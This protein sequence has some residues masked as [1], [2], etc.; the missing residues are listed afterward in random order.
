M[1]LTYT[2]N[3][4]A[5]V[6]TRPVTGPAFN[7]A[8]INLIVIHYTAADDLID[9]D[10]GESADRLDDYIRSAHNSYLNDPNRGYSL[11]YSIAV[12]WLGGTWEIRGDTFKCAA[13]LNLNDRAIAI[14]VLVDW[15]DPAS[16]FA[17]AAI[18]NLVSQIR[19]K[20][21]GAI[22]IGHREG[23]QYHPKA[24]KTR[25]PGDGVFA[26]L[27]AGVFEPGTT[28]PADPP[29]DPG[30]TTSTYTVVAG[31][32]WFAIGRKTGVEVGPLLAVNGASLSTMLHPGQ[33][34]KVPGT[35]P[36]P[37]TPTDWISKG[38]GFT[39]PDGQP[40]MKRGQVHSDTMWLQ[41]VLCSM[42]GPDGNPIY[43]PAWV[44]GDSTNNGT[45]RNGQQYFGDATFNSVKFWQSHNGL[46]ADGEFG[47]AS[48]ARMVA[49]RGK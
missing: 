15:Q 6:T 28:P 5:W 11:G 16:K 18:Q 43:N 49:V 25:C 21:P 30:P 39:S 46:T 29:T 44:G 8:G 36:Q 23:P 33:V 24:T 14:L 10:P 45:V 12:D 26:Q 20:A 34:L 37:G 47:P 35:A 40:L 7:W 41:A 38:M 27:K 48:S 42:P 19:A 4:S 9:G 22:I 1:T 32:G 2:H 13:N 17:T 31:D 3:R